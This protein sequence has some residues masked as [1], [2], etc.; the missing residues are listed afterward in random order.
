MPVA[1]AGAMKG[2]TFDQLESFSPY[3]MLC[4]TFHMHLDPG[5]DIVERAGGL[6]KFIN[7]KKPILTD[8]GGFQ[9]FSLSDI[10]KIDDDGVTFKSP[11]DGSE[12]RFTPES[13]MEIQHKLGADIIMCLDHCPPSTASRKEIEEAT[14]RTINW[15][16]RCKVRHEELCKE[17]GTN[18]LLFGIVQGG[19]EHD[20]R[21]MCAKALSDIE[22][23]GYAVGGLAVG[24]TPEQMF[25]V[26]THVCPVLPKD[27]PRYLMG[28]G[29]V[30]QME[31]AV[32]LGIDMFD[33]VLPMREARHGRLFMTDGST[34]RITQAAFRDDHSVIDVDS[35]SSLSREHTRS[36]LHHLNRIGERYGETIACMQNVSVTLLKM[37]QLREKIL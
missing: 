6:H 15:A 24:E 35:P 18:P 1:T 9:V 25:E 34:V 27:A 13:A 20:L 3:V 12:H 11:R 29:R 22:F 30:D 36:Y 16:K 10:R 31:K 19:L 4:N 23:D 33:C 26:L 21:E 32:A 37:K 5:E 2:I 28:V 14:T 8:S 7:W 17:R